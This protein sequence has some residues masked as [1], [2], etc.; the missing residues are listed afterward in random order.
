VFEGRVLLK[1]WRDRANSRVMHETIGKTLSIVLPSCISTSSS[2]TSGIFCYLSRSSRLKKDP[3]RLRRHLE[4]TS[5]AELLTRGGQH[6]SM[7]V[8][9]ETSMGDIVIDLE[10]EACPA[11][12][13]NFLKLCKVY[14]YN[15]NAFFNGVYYLS[16]YVSLC[17]TRCS[18]PVSKDFLAQT[19]DPTAT[20][21]GGECILSYIASEQPSPPS[22]P[23]PRYFV[24]TI[25]PRFKHT[26]R[27][28]VSMA[29]APAPEGQKGGCGSQFFITLA[30][31]LEY[32][33]GKH[34]VFGH[35]VEG[36]DTLDKLNEVFTDGSG[37]PLKDMRIR[38]AI[39]LGKSQTTSSESVFHI[40]CDP[41]TDHWAC[42]GPISGSTRF[43]SARRATHPPPR[44]QL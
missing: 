4:P 21:S 40:L 34:A 23:V 11:L 36:F 10:V 30:D 12:C 39:I 7:S 44:C 9:F 2:Y 17:L 1:R 43:E 35:V 42:R 19:G 32:L 37:R 24:P 3:N 38:H 22:Q 26:A 25:L 33:D 28:T 6:P 13:E 27:G 29:V 20:G 41:C 31:N 14:Y 16:T 15:L 8:L 5:R 18:L